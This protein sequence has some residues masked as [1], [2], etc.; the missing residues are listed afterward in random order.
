MVDAAS[1]RGAGPELVRQINEHDPEVKVV[2]L[3]D[4]HAHWEADYRAQRIHYY[5]IDPFS[6]GEIQD[7]LDEVFRV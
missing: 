3:G 5:A 7:I 1:L 6:D 4:R 2:V